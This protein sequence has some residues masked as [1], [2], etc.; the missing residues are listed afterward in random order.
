MIEYIIGF[1]LLCVVF[2]LYA[3][4]LGEFKSGDRVIG[5]KGRIAKRQRTADVVQCQRVAKRAA[6]KRGAA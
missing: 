4:H 3:V 6:R 5:K 1:A 2:L